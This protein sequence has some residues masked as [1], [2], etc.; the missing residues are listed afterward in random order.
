MPIYVDHLIIGGGLMGSATAWQLAKQGHTVTLLERFTP[1]HTQGA[2]HGTSRIYRNTYPVPEYLDLAAEALTLWRELER[3]TGTDL[4]AMTG[5]ISSGGDALDAQAAILV[6]RAIPAQI[7]PNPDARARF[8]W[9]SFG[10]RVLVEPQTAG[11]LHADRAV[12][13]LK[14]AATKNGA[15]VVH[16]IRVLAIEVGTAGVQVRT[17]QGDF[18]AGSVLLAVGA[19]TTTLAG[20]ITG[21][22]DAQA[23]RLTPLNRLVVTQEQ[24]AH[25]RVHPEYAENLAA[26]PS[27][28]H[29]PGPEH[30]GPGKRWPSGAY[31]LLS[32]DEP[33]GP[34]VKVG[35]HGVGPVTDPDRRTIAANPAQLDQLI[36]YVRTHIP[37]LDPD[38]ADPLSCTYTTTLDHDFILDRAGR[39][40][41]AAGF[42]GHG[43]KFGPALGRVLAALMTEARTAPESPSSATGGIF[44]LD[45]T[46]LI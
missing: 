34:V 16:N 46:G 32:V 18:A 3:E 30:V 26:F 24:P 5:G 38:T 40:V 14:S 37:A 44:A 8:P 12:A 31:G 11:R 29:D 36:D 35:F 20:S 4:L 25:F 39:V 45:R 7:L 22:S 23:A 10:D 41:V 28:T 43:F 42:S 27:F 1:G 19:W 21:L 15:T 33:G 9:F 17:D 2:S 13:A 6:E